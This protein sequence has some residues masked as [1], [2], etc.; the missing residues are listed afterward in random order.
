MTLTGDADLYRL[1]AELRAEILGRE[2]LE[3]A[4]RDEDDLDEYYHLF[5]HECCYAQV[6]SRPGLS[7]LDRAL[8]T[9][10]MIAALGPQSVTL[11]VHVRGVI[12]S[13]GTRAQLSQ[14]LAMITWY[15]GVPV[16]S[17]ATATVRAALIKIPE[18]EAQVRGPAQPVVSSSELAARGS[19][20]R[21]L[22][23]GEPQPTGLSDMETAHQRMQE[24]HFFGVLWSNT[25]LTLKQ[26]CLVLLGVI[27]GSNRMEDM[28]EWFAAA[29]R[30]GYKVEELEEVVFSSSAYCGQL[31]YATARKALIGA[32]ISQ[33]A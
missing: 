29:L 10:S 18:P 5:G 11:G 13:G 23:L 27:S 7:R 33:K 14:I 30:L 25:D 24:T 26:R 32:A 17:Q 22:V 31:T 4:L 16:G 1:G 28:Q 8:V 9:F 19:A 21:R 3:Q 15:A 20:L 6:W 12:R 2:R